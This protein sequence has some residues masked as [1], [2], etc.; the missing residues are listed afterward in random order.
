MSVECKVVNAER[1]LLTLLKVFSVS[2]TSNGASV[3]R[4]TC[5]GGGA[6]FGA[7]CP[8]LVWCMTLALAASETY[9]WARHYE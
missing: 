2:H 8:T 5:P 4:G 1:T 7:V 6:L 9:S 3:W